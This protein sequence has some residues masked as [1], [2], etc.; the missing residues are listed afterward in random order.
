MLWTK[1]DTRWLKRIKQY[2][3]NE[4]KLELEEVGF[5]NG[6]QKLYY[7]T[8]VLS[9][10]LFLVTGLLMWFGDVVPRWLVAVSYVIHD[11]AA[12][13]MLAGFI[14]H[15]Y[16]G[17]A[18]MPGTFRAMTNG[19][20]TEKWAWTHHPAWY[21]AVTSRNPRDAYE[22]DKTRQDDRARAMEAWEREHDISE[23][24]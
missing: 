18:A 5:F 12:L 15:I 4:D 10:I 14:I 11:L 8:I 24:S 22:R 9:G 13:L 16:E 6:G 3:T 19:T 21:H 2:T 20:V 7:W 23:R 1:T 17:T